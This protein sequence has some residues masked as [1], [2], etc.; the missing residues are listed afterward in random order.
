MRRKPP[1][2]PSDQV[3]L[4]STSRYSVYYEDT[5][6]S[7]YVYH[8]NYLKYF[9]R[10]R[11]DLIGLRYLRDLYQRGLHFVVARAEVSYHKPA[12]HGDTL[13]VS[14]RMPL[15][16]RPVVQVEHVI[17][18]VAEDGSAPVVLVTGSV[19]LAFVDAAGELTAVPPDVMSFFAGLPK[20]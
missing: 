19:K 15:V 17:S 20:G 6:F 10:G 4:S 14:T 13:E 5:D 11:E 18:R 1:Q 8:A 9:E 7:G 12:Q 16:S 3:W 2:Y